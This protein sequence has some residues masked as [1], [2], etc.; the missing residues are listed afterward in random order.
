MSADRLTRR[1]RAPWALKDYA[2]AA[3][4]AVYLGFA[5]VVL[6]SGL[7]VVAAAVDPAFH[8]YLHAAGFTD[9]SLVE[10]VLLGI[11]AA[12]HLP[13]SAPGIALDYTFSL[14]NIGLALQLIRLRPRNRTARLLALGMIGTAAVFNLE[15][16][17]VFEKMTAGPLESAFNFVLQFLA[18]MSY[19][20]ALLTFPDGRFIPRWRRG[21]LLLLYGTVVVLMAWAT[22]SLHGTHRTSVIVL[23][24]LVAPLTAVASQAYRLRSSHTEQQRQQARL[25]FWAM[26]PALL[27]G[28]VVG[29]QAV[30]D[31]LAPNPLQGRDLVELPVAAFRLF[32]PVFLI[33]PV[34]VMVGIIRYR[35]WDVD[36]LI[37][38]TLVYGA[39]AAVIS[40]LYIGVVVVIG[41]LI[42]ATHN[43]G[44]SIAATGIAAAA[45]GPLRDRFQRLA[46][47]LVYGKR[48]T[49]Y[50][51]LAQFSERVGDEVGTEELLQRM[52]QVLAEGTGSRRAQV[53]LKVGDVLRGAASWPA[54]ENQDAVVALDQEAEGQ[55][56]GA[57]SLVAGAAGGLLGGD[58]ELPP[59]PGA[60]LAVPVRHRGELL[61]ALSV[62]KPGDDGLSATEEKLVHD[63]AAQAG[64]VLRNLALTSELR[65]RLDDL[66]QSRQRILTAGNEARKRLERDIHDGA[67]QQLVALMVRLN[68]AERVAE[69]QSPQLKEM[70]AQLKSD[71]QDA[72]ENLRDL[73]RGIYPPLL[74]SNGLVAALEGQARK[75]QLPVEIQAHDLGRYDEETEF[76]VYFCVLEALQ[77][78]VKSAH[79][80][81][82]TVRLESSLGSLFFRVEDDGQGFDP[83]TVKRGS[84]LR[85]MQD[86]VEALGGTLVMTSARGHGTTISGTIPAPAR[87]ELARAASG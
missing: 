77:N 7:G 82:A 86:R 52:V 53:W 1:V 72:L 85:N 30:T 38:R 69:K 31:Y 8:A 33:I 41:N 45:F 57:R 74:A 14:F 80:T 17:S 84:G 65:A 67:Q 3:T 75:V 16:Y 83:P 48:A 46:N 63:L 47:H 66:Q 13:Q 24:G 18:A 20:F 32:Q 79:A 62:S 51:V 58:D 5:L 12:S 29:G 71:T 11:A 36:Q 55:A 26:T 39:L 81:Q 64:L 60:A 44:L 54:A 34:A 59:I 2:F 50:E 6:V 10:H 76:A 87:S 40:L 43:L 4:F 68:L 78:V 22:S 37:S 61:G 21:P 15:A 70:L 49:P 27:L 23:F 25:L 73:A 35:L 28:L 19:F 42:G 56:Q 9:D